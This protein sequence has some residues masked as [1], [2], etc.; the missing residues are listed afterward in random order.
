MEIVFDVIVSTLAIGALA[1]YSWSAR[2]HFKSEGMPRG[3]KLLTLVVLACALLM[4]ALVWGAAQPLVAQLVGI[5]LMAASY[6]LFWAAIQASRSATL[7]L[8]FDPGNP[9]SFVSTGP[10]R[11]VRHPFYVSYTIFWGGWAIASWSI[12]ALLPLVFMVGLYVGA[13]RD[14]ERKF[15]LTGMATAYQDYRRRTGFFFPKVLG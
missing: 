2:G 3:A 4:F 6:G 7:L 9:Q 5:G 15:A 11:Y 13:A 8:A 12:W 14:E 1:Q 10:Y